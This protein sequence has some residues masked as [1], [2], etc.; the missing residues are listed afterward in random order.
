LEELERI[1]E[2]LMHVKEEKEMTMVVKQEK[3]REVEHTIR[4]LNK[5]RKLAERILKTVKNLSSISKDFNS[6]YKT[7]MIQKDY[8]SQ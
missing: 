2:M 1:N 8:H 3:E 4:V 7:K 6:E 5:N